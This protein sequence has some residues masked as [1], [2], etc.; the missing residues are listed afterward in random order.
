[1]KK[2]IL[3]F[4]DGPSKNFSKLLDYLIKNNHKAIFFC[5]GENLEKIKFEEH[6]IKA[7][8]NGFIIANHSY[9]HPNF[10][11]ISFDK[12]KNEIIKTDKIIAKLY[13]KARI[14]QEIKLFRFPSF[15]EGIFHFFKYQ[16]LLKKLDYSNYYHKKNFFNFNLR[17]KYFIYHLFQGI[18]IGRYDVYCEIDPAD[19]NK[20]ISFEKMKVLLDKARNNDIIDLHDQEHSLNKS[21]K[22]ICEYLYVKG[23]ELSKI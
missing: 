19:W 10:N 15:R 4:D 21:T 7:I 23:F 17:K 13:E 1:M 18:F 6:L 11:F 20:K 9:S 12:G 5:C 2:I 16:R 22:K 8:K 14:K 3:T